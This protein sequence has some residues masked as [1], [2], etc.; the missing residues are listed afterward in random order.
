MSRRSF[1]HAVAQ[2]K[3]HAEDVAQ[4]KARRSILWVPVELPAEA[5][6]VEFGA[7]GK[8]WQFVVT[9]ENGQQKITAAAEV[10]FIAHL[11]TEANARDHYYAPMADKKSGNRLVRRKK[12]NPVEQLAICLPPWSSALLFEL[13]EKGKADAVKEFLN[14]SAVRVSKEFEAISKRRVLGISIHTDSRA[15]HF[16]LQFSRVG[17]VSDGDFPASELAPEYG[18]ERPEGRNVLVGQRALGTIGASTC[19]GLNRMLVGAVLPESDEYAAIQQAA[20]GFSQR[21]GCVPLD[22][23]LWKLVNELFYV[24]FGVNP[25]LP[26]L[27]AAYKR[28]SIAAK[29]AGLN[30]IKDRVEGQ[31]AALERQIRAANLAD[32]LPGPGLLLLP[33]SPKQSAYPTLR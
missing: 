9:R 31:V 14:R 27:V 28:Q 29:M 32:I 20:H 13:A 15:I 26:A 4:A 12:P 8:G 3:I 25:R 5:K 18:G 33:T 17:I 19:A 23:T 10:E 16:H 6:R 7:L 22:W 1:A 24:A 11:Q 2:S 30:A 21:R